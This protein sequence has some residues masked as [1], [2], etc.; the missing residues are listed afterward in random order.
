MPLWVTSAAKRRDL[1]VFSTVTATLLGLVQHQ[2]VCSLSLNQATS[3]KR[4]HSSQHE[5]NEELRKLGIDPE[6]SA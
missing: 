1:A 5:V 4:D 3:S 6:V 2:D